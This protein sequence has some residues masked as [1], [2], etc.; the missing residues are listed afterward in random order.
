MKKILFIAPHAFPIRSSESICNAKV[1]FALA[2]AGYDVDV[3][4]CNYPSTYPPDME[5][6]T[7]L[8]SL[9]NLKIRYI[10]PEYII[11]RSDPKGKLLRSIAY[12]VKILLQTGYF[13]NGASI[14]YLIYKQIL[15]DV[16]RL[17]EFN[18]DVIM[19][20]GYFTDI[21]GILLHKKFRTKWIA[22]WNDPYP[23]QKF[24]PPY[25][26]G[27]FTKLPFFENRI[28]TDLKKRADFHTFPNNRLRDYMLKCFGSVDINHT[29]VIPHMALSM[30]FSKKEAINTK[31]RLVHTGNLTA[32]RSPIRFLKALAK[33]IHDYP[34][35]KEKIECI[36]VG[37]TEKTAREYINE[38]GLE[39][40]V[41]ILKGVN[42][43]EALKYIRSSNVSL[44]IEAECEEGIYL[45]TKVVDSLQT[46]TPIFAISPDRGVLKD[47]LQSYKIGY[48]SPNNSEDKIYETLKKIFD[49]Y[50][51]NKLPIISPQSCPIFFDE[52]IIES[53]KAILDR[54]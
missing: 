35:N 5:L 11:R 22:N 12:N 30:L 52:S 9:S 19:T 27:P 26:T 47:L 4:T 48:F 23:I 6:N 20:R 14:P 37:E 51:A 45:P 7:K 38:Y 42:Y 1:A 44:I 16:E 54:M 46:G 29:A 2:E 40:N 3:Y 34:C 21:A 33:Y 13:Y 32:P 39:D 25:G 15:K 24:P 17:G 36:L 10:Y 43:N 31:L 18:Y 41:T 53:Y 50:T 8:T 49:D 28:Y